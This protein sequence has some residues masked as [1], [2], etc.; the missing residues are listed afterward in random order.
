M[1]RLLV[2]SGD[3]VSNLS[4]VGIVEKNHQVVEVRL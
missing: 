1:E 4:S 2:L 3:K